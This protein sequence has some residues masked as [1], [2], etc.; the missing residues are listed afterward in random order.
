MNTYVQHL[1]SFSLL[2]PRGY[3]DD[4]T[5]IPPPR[6]INNQCTGLYN[7]EN[8]ECVR[9]RNV[10]DQGQGHDFL[11]LRCPRGRGQSSR[12]MV[13][14]ATGQNGDKSK[15]RQTKTATGPKSTY[16][17]DFVNYGPF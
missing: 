13:K 1:L 3:S 6:V 9:V 8:Q 5:V 4:L 17:L 12:G 11:S 16:K 7:T 2:I 10:Q 15:R 14:T